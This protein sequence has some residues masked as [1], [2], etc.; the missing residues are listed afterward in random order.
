M[1]VLL[2]FLEGC[3]FKGKQIFVEE[4]AEYELTALTDRELVNDKYYI[5]NGSKFY[6]AYKPDGTVSSTASQVDSNRLF[7]LDVDESLI[8]T[9]Y[10]GELIAYPS[11]NLSL[12]KISIE[13]FSDVGYS[14]GLYGG[15]VDE[16]GYFCYKLKENSIGVSNAYSVLSQSKSDQIRITTI[17]DSPVDS[18]SINSSGIITG[19]S[20]NEEYTI[21]YY[22]GT[23]YSTATVKADEH[24]LQSYEIINIEKAETTK[25]G[26]LAITLPNDAKSGYYFINGYGIFKYYD[27]KKGEKNDDKTDMNEPYY[28]SSEEQLMANSQKYVVNVPTKA[29][30]ISFTVLYNA[31]AIDVES[32]QC[33]LQSPSGETYTMQVKEAGTIFLQLAEAIA[34]RWSI[35]IS[36]KDIE[37]IDVVVDAE[38]PNNTTVT[39]SYDFV[40]T[41]DNTNIQFIAEY[42]GDGDIW[43]VVKNENGETVNL[44]L[45]KDNKLSAVYR[46]LPAG[47]YTVTIY[48]YA[49]TTVDNA[50]YQTYEDNLENEIITIEE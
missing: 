29:N 18:N 17:N 49:D 43:G 50:T 11:E 36:P 44:E 25:N 22:A 47:T 4:G 10:K 45:Q 32:I 16:E 1:A 26:Y 7:W 24:F 3:G 2:I 38:T 6:E 23:Y 14:I 21:G 12:D 48:H 13:R 31:T 5:K 28:R 42:T 9:Y 8:P 34:G 20:K 41:E 33:I 19:L 27:Y 39:D 30:N 35:S 46:Y 40:I 37:I 15:T